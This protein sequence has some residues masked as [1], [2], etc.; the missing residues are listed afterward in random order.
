MKINFDIRLIKPSFSLEMQGQVAPTGIT[1]VFGPSGCGKTSFLRVLAGL[2][3]MA[4]GN[5]AVGE[6]VWM[7]E[8]VFLEPHKRAIGY[9]FQQPS[10]F[11]HLNVHNNILYGRK[12]REGEG[13]ELTD[14]IELLG[15]QHLLER[16]INTLSGGEQ[17]RVAIARALASNPKILLMDEPMAS[18]DLARKQEIMPFMDNLHKELALPILLV[19]HSH[20][21]VGH[22]AD[23][24]LVMEQGRL[25]AHGK[26]SHILT[27]S[28]L[29]LFAQQ[30]A[31][32]VLT[33][34]VVEHDG[35]NHLT[36]LDTCA[37][38]FWVS[39]LEKSV[40]SEVRLQILARDVSITL[41]EP[42]DSS[43]LNIVPGKIQ[44]LVTL[45]DGQVMVKVDC[46]GGIVLSRITRRSCHLLDLQQGMSVYVQVKGIAVLS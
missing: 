5:L 4:K 18:L 46:Q 20:H 33:G 37:G 31:L 45:P 36:L 8:E 44:E 21:E 13:A 39:K 12:R 27:Q 25:I 2:E 17:Q 32:S 35:E 29:S 28:N 22:L 34:S 11:P 9:V 16:N 42:T 23:D 41:S 15:L 40:A 24:M 26:V 6:Q 3:P 10:L 14:V 7:S 38:Q 43:I 19:S 30:E 1:A